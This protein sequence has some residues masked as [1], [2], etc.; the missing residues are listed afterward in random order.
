MA[1]TVK[2][3]NCGSE[4]EATGKSCTKCAAYIPAASVAEEELEE[5]ELDPTLDCLR[6]IDTSLKTIKSIALWWLILSI[7]GVIGLLVYILNRL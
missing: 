6:S 7:L 3:P 4:G 5:E 1:E 2:C